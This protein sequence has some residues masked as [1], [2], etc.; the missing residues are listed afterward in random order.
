MFAPTFRGGNQNDK[1]EVVAEVP[2]LDFDRL[3]KVIQEKFGGEW[4]ILLRLHPQL[5]AKMDKMPLLSKDDRLI[6]VSQEPDISEIMGGCDAVITDYSSC[7]FDAA[8]A[9]IPV[10]L[11]ADDVQDY[12]RN[13]GQ[14]MWKREELPF[15]LAET[16]DMD[17]QANM[18]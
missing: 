16:N 5:S 1:K 8:F 6:D 17:M 4:K 11:F 7:A 10:F 12:V 14:F 3:I 15:S 18:S 9:K 2:Q 13:R